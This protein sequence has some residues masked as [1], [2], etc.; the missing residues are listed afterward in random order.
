[1]RLIGTARLAYLRSLA[2]GLF[3]S[4]GCDSRG[5]ACLPDCTTAMAAASPLA[6][7]VKLNVRKRT[8]R[9]RAGALTSALHQKYYAGPLQA[10]SA[11][12][13]SE[14]NAIV[15]GNHAAF[16]TNNQKTEQ[17]RCNAV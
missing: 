12:L 9:H 8:L 7:G 5:I 3:P 10:R 13:V 1:M 2:V 6:G 11:D 16:I 17:H 14:I 15:G 4:L